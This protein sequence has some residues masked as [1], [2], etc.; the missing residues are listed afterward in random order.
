MKDMD[1]LETIELFIN[2]EDNSGIEAISLVEFPAIEENFV[3]LSKHKIELK[4]MDDE[5]RLV[6][7]LALVPDKKIYRNNGGFEYNITFSKDTVRKAAEKYLKSLKIHNAT[8]E[9][10]MEVDGVYLTESWI[11]EDKAKDKTALYDLNAPEGAW[12]VAMRIE[13]ENVWNDIKAGK[14]LGFSIEGIFNENEGW[15]EQDLSVMKK[16]NQLLDELES[17][18]QLKSYSDYPEAARNNAKRALDWA[19]KNGWGSCG[20]DVGKKRASM[21]ASGMP[22]S[23]ETIARMASFKRHQQHKDV[24][25]NEGCGGLMWDSWGGTAG[26]EWAIKK[27]AEIDREELSEIDILELQVQNSLECDKLTLSEQKFSDYPEA[28]HKNALRALKYKIDN[29]V[30]CGTKA[31]W[32]FTKMLAKKQPIS[33]CLISQMASYVR[34]RRDKDVPYSKGCGKLLWDAWGG[35]AG[36]NWASKKIKEIDRDIEPVDSID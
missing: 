22:L 20:T 9:H 1:D 33:R 28:A 23:R 17:S 24:P 15:D 27:L 35:D 2:D 34:F 26:V 21:L 36:I 30:Q 29:K 5:K 11:V 13:N 18:Q 4:T 25:Y 10:E 31:G 12:A 8:V 3:A 7:G 32:Q 19:E 14:Y 6:I 16:I